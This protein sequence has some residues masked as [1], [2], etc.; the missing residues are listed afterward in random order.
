MHFRASFLLL[1]SLCWTASAEPKAYDLVKYKGKA[2]G[3]T[4]AFD[5][6]EGYPQASE[7]RITNAASKKTT[8]FVLDESGEMR[9]VPEKDKA[10]GA[11]VILQM[12]MDDEAPPKVNG[13]YTTNGKMVSFT[14]TRQ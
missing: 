7:V 8:R 13:S 4:I 1:L 14:L 12:S 9:F 11:R 10:S 2:G 5:Y 6:G 3:V